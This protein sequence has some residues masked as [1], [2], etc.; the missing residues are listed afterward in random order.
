MEE[1]NRGPP[2]SLEPDPLTLLG[3]LPEAVVL[4]VAM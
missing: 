2:A 1:L 4:A 3:H